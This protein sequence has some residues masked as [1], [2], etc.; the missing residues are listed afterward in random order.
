MPRWLACVDQ[1]I[2][3]YQ[4][5]FALQLHLPAAP[6]LLAENAHAS[7]AQPGTGRKWCIASLWER[8]NLRRNG[9][10]QKRRARHARSLTTLS[11]SPPRHHRTFT[12]VADPVT[13]A[14]HHALAAYTA[15]IA[16]QSR[17]PRASLAQAGSR[18][19]ILE[20]SAAVVL[21]VHHLRARSNVCAMV[22]A[23]ARNMQ[24]AG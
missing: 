16:W 5:D 8:A 9:N 14:P 17:L 23:C 11:L 2:R 1:E 18:S 21:T 3:A 13:Q 6:E 12:S 7:S 19:A 24:Q 15:T 10:R 22:H 4:R 20:V